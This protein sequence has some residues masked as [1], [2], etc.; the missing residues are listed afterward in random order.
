VQPR[1]VLGVVALALAGPGTKIF[2]VWNSAMEPTLHC[3]HP[4]PGCLA[5]KDDRVRTRPLLPGEPRRFDIIVLPTTPAIARK[6]GSGNFYIKRVIGL[7]GETVSE[8]N[9]RVLVDGKLL[10]EPYVKFRENV[11]GG[12][13]HVPA[14]RYFVLG[15]N[16]PESCDSRYWG[17]V[18][19]RNVVGKAVKIQR[20]SKTIRLP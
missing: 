3:A 12:P 6:C 2:R 15:D 11:S 10:N 9:G 4:G 20:G 8:R 16:R 18:P 14:G 13:W 19:R 17:S 1:I 5:R 7:P